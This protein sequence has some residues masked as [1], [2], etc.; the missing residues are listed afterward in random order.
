[1]ICL[2]TNYLIRALIPQTHE[3]QRVKEWLVSREAFCIASVA[4]YEFLCGCTP[5]EQSIA[6]ALVG[7]RVLPFRDKE[8]ILAAK[9]FRILQKP[10]RLRVDAMIAATAIVADCPLATN[11]LEDFHP[12]RPHGLRMI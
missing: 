2:D 12:F 3:A 8:A 1:M 5:E 11:N 9:C 4:W 10:R 6:M 7:G